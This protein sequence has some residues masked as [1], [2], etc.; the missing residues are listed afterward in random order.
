MNYSKKFLLGG[1]LSFAFCQLSYAQ[2]QKE[3]NEKPPFYAPPPSRGIEVE[4]P[5]EIHIRVDEMASPKKGNDMN[6]IRTVFAKKLNTKKLVGEGNIQT[7]ITFV[8]EKDGSITNMKSKGSNSVFNEEA[9]KTM[10]SI[11]KKEKWNPAKIN[12]KEVRSQYS[13]PIRM[14]FD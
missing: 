5:D 9:Q 14:V 7:I 2:A 10:E 11:L 12:N 3:T 1:I 6:G 8:V 4:N 13:I